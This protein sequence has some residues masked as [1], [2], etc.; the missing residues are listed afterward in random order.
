M[1]AMATGRGPQT[2]DL[3]ALGAASVEVTARA[4]LRAAETATGLGG[5]P[6]IGEINHG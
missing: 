5:V 6:S 1:F 2:S 4:V 3:T